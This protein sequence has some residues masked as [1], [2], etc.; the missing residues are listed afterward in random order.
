MSKKVYVVVG[1]CIPEGLAKE[2][3]DEVLNGMVY[4]F[5][6]PEVLGAEIVENQYN[7]E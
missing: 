4:D 6:H 3:I 1:I 7:Y 5:E 2:E